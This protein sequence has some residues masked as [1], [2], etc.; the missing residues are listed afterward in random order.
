MASQLL[1]NI[2]EGRVSDENAL[3]LYDE[4]LRELLLR[5]DWSNITKCLELVWVLAVSKRYVELAVKMMQTWRTVFSLDD[6]DHVGSY[7]AEHVPISATWDIA[8][9]LNDMDPCDPV[10]DSAI[11]LMLWQLEQVDE[12][13]A[14]DLLTNHTRLDFMQTFAE[15]TPF[16]QD[17]ENG[18]Y[19]ARPRLITG[20]EM[21]AAYKTPDPDVEFEDYDFLKLRMLIDAE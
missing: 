7:L 5:R 1:Y 19:D 2:V 14:E 9:I 12:E 13:M 16:I 6:Y 17:V 18:K 15:M 4:I 21:M 8:R 20:V 10:L 11:D 3:R